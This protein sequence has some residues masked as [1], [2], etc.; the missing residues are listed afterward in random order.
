MAAPFEARDGTKRD[1]QRFVLLR[2]SSYG[3]HSSL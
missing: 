1:E 3:G 2:S